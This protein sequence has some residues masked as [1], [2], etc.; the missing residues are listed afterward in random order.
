MI[1]PSKLRAL[2]AEYQKNSTIIEQVGGQI[3]RVRDRLSQVDQT[4]AVLSGKGG[5]GKSSLTVNLAAAFALQGRRVG[6]LDAD[7]N[8][9]CIPAMLGIEEQGC[10]ITDDGA[11]P[12]T[13]YLG[14]KV[15]SMALLLSEHAPVQ[16]KAPK[17]AWK[18]AWS[19]MLEM[20]VVRELIADVAWG[21]LDVLLIDMPPGTGDKPAVIAQLIPDLDGTVVVSIPSRVARSVV[22]RSIRFCGELGLPVIGLVEN[23]AGYVCTACGVE[24]HLFPG[25]EDAELAG[26][27]VLGRVPFDP[28]LGRAADEGVP[29]LEAH[30]ESPAAS[31]IRNIAALVGEAITQK[32]AFLKAL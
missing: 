21:P 26:V 22:E 16:W 19:G 4:I 32:R 25:G 28:R 30:G 31:A 29:F 11:V 1:E 27:P 23:M 15:A 9:P 20:S 7:I 18:A 3:A 17:G 13:G 8:G 5:V 12:A 10:R 24:G 14:I 2:D 6:I